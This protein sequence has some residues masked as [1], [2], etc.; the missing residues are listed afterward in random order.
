VEL[1][2]KC[3]GNYIVLGLYYF[4]RFFQQHAELRNGSV[5]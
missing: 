2:R 3:I 4:R 1:Q 5:S